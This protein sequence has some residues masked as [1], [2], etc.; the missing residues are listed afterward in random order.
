[1]YNKEIKTVKDVKQYFSYLVNKR[2]LNFH[3][4]TDFSEYVS[5]KTGKSTFK[6][7]EIS[8]FNDLMENSF[9][10]CALEKV[11]IYEIGLKILKGG[12]R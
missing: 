11:D 2:K 5:C 4:D 1:M 12:F 8:H 9:R 3:P 6:D 7:E 10:I